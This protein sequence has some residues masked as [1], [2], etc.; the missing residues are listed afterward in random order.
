MAELTLFDEPSRWG[1][2]RWP[3]G[4]GNLPGLYSLWPAVYGA[5]L[6]IEP[7]DAEKGNPELNL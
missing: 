7:D 6:A 5:P 2:R 4:Y 1:E 3:E